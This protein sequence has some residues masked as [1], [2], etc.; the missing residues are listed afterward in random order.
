MFRAINKH[1]FVEEVLGLML[2]AFLEG[3]LELFYMHKGNL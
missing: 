1:R 3:S 2:K